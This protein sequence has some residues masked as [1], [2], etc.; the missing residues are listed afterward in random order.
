MDKRFIL[1]LNRRWVSQ[2]LTNPKLRRKSWF[3]LG[4]NP[5]WLQRNT[6]ILIR[7]RSLDGMIQLDATAR[8]I[9]R[10]EGFY[11]ESRCLV[12]D[13]L[14]REPVDGDIF[15]IVEG[16]TGGARI[17]VHIDDGSLLR[18]L[19]QD[20]PTLRLPAYDLPPITSTLIDT[21]V[22]LRALSHRLH[23]K[24]P[25]LYPRRTDDFVRSPH[26]LLSLLSHVMELRSKDQ[27]DFLGNLRVIADQFRELLSP[28]IRKLYKS[29]Q[30]L[31]KEWAGTRISFVDGGTA[32]VSGL[33]GSEPLAIRVG[34][35]SVIPG[36]TDLESREHWSLEP[37]VVGD[38]INTPADPDVETTEPP[39][40]KRLLEAARY[41][42]ES[43]TVLSHMS[44]SLRPKV[45]FLHG[46]LVNAFETYDEG[47]PYHIPAIDPA[48]LEA[49]GIVEDDVVASIRN[50]PR[51]LDGKRMWNHCMAVYCY[52]M[53]KIFEHP[54]PAVGVVE[55]SGS[56]AF[57]KAVIQCLLEEGEIQPSLARKLRKR[58]DQYRISDEIL[59]GCVLD[60]GEYVEPLPISK[61]FVHRARDRWQPVVAEYPNPLTTYL[62]TSP[63]N[64][65]YRVEINRNESSPEISPLM[66]LLYHSSCLLPEYAFPVGLDIADK[67][68]RVPDW[69]SRGVSAAIAA[70]ALSRAAATGEPRVLQQV[71]RLLAQSPRDFFFRPSS[72]IPKGRAF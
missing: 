34:V 64:F 54:V 1:V 26:I 24:D 43:L 28:R 53:R 25:E 69:L 60:E 38:I 32:R 16:S 57:A 37:Y 7:F 44:S 70:H 46:P 68:A 33:P 42:L 67:F 8:L 63:S 52:I 6:E 56:N 65:P 40:P 12:E 21:P 4:P 31:W 22:I 48:F 15:V 39:D 62:K 50:I 23:S 47:E 9:E 41:I 35:Y 3:P 19:G 61:N 14:A 66:D 45:V 10:P 29:H 59:F 13:V 5:S 2:V 17:V 27:I 58:L 20:E 36:E 18:N 71:R 49:H 30:R 11:V 72:L 51:R 55:R